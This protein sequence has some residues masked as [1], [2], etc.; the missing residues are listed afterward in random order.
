MISL[1]LVVTK[2]GMLSFSKLYL[3]FLCV[4]GGAAAFINTSAYSYAAQAYTDDVE[5][6]I[7]IM[8][9]V[10]GIGCAAGP[11]L[12]SVVYELIGFAWTFIL[13]GIIMAPTSI[14]LCF[15]KKPTEVKADLEMA[16]KQEKEQRE[17][18]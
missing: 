13:F 14:I 12:G 3:F 11:V 8:E 1:A 16:A 17:N 7:S 10:V 2:G 9:T 18:Q 4:L 5:K 15:L 6:V